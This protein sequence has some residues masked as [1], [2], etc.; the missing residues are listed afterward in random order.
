MTTVRVVVNL[1]RVKLTTREVARLIEEL[2]ALETVAGRTLAAMLERAARETGIA[3]VPDDRVEA[4][5]LL[6]AADHLRNLSL[7]GPDGELERLAADEVEFTSG[8]GELRDRL[9][10]A[11]NATLMVYELEIADADERLSF[12]SYS[13]LYWTGDRL[14][15]A[16]K[17]FRVVAA[18]QPKRGAPGRLAVEPWRPAS[19][20]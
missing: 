11:L 3:Y 20:Y 12:G 4:L 13:G 10:A 5:V 18:A 6:R 8:L 9:V 17:P 14:V 15:A 1:A 16:T 2:E 7:T 19:R